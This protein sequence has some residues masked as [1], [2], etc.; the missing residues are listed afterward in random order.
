MKLSR[1]LFATS[2]FLAPTLLEA[3]DISIGNDDSKPIEERVIYSNE[4]TLH[5][6][7]HSRGLS[8]GYKSG[9]IR[10]IYKTTNWDFELVYYRSQK[11][12]KLVDLF[13][14]A[15][16]VYGKL[17]DMVAFRT[18]YG[19]ER[20]IYGK[21]YWGG[22]ELRWLYEGGASLALLKPYY[23]DETFWYGFSE[24]KLRPGIYAR[25]GMC[26][27]IGASRTHAQSIEVG[28]NIEYFPQGVDLMELNPTEYVFLTLY[29]SYNWGSRYNK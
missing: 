22:V 19:A 9:K 16:F 1:L 25:G 6:T 18:G 20:R 26:F 8:L 14:G 4:S 5:A 24:I 10:S 17:N 15:T 12:V 23:P 28:T 7:L 2:L 21:P 29:L 11:Q 13:S 27:E 3:Q